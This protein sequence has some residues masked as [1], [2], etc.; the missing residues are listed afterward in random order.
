MR[1]EKRLEIDARARLHPN[2][3]S[4]MEV[5]VLDLSANGF[6]AECD[7]RVPA[8]TCVTLEVPGVG[9][10][11]A[12]VTWRKGTRFGAQFAGPIAMSD[13]SWSPA[14]AETLLA[15]LLVDRADARATGQFGPELELRRRILAGLP[16]RKGPAAT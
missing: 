4:S 9:P 11:M 16:I 7:A 15:R 1:R 8:G 3:W 5:R 6:R 2:D 14:G 12:Y 13:C 10:S